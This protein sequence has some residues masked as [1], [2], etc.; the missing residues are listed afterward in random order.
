MGEFRMWINYQ[1]GS[2]IGEGGTENGNII[3]DEEHVDGARITLEQNCHQKV[4]GLRSFAIN[5][6]FPKVFRSLS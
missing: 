6:N 4:L 2:T 1:N 3:F 5:I